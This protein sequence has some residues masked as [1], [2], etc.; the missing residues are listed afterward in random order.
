MLLNFEGV[1]CLS[2]NDRA[3]EDILMLLNARRGALG[4][5]WFLVFLTACLYR[6]CACVM[7]H[8]SSVWPCSTLSA[9]ARQAP[10]STGIL[11]ARV[12]QWVGCRAL[13]QGICRTQRSTPRFLVSC[14]GRWVPYHQRCLGSP[15]H[16]GF[17]HSVASASLRP[18]GL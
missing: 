14:S 6:V 16:R 10:L 1:Y 2:E 18:Q 13:L 4:V 8:F 9:V 7:S 5:F 3:S 11:Q 12:L 17:S 15:V